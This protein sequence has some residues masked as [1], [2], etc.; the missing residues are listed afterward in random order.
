MRNAIFVFAL[1]LGA[2]GSVRSQ[3]DAGKAPP[4]AQDAATA[5]RL[6]GYLQRWEQEMRKVQTLAAA[7]QRTDT[8]KTFGTKTTFVGTAQY[9]K[10]GTGPTSLNLAALELKQQGKSEVA[11]KFICTGTY[12][13]KFE[14]A[15]KEIRAYKMPKPQPGQVAD[16]SF[17]GF[18]F[19]MRAE[20]AKRRYNL[21]FSKAPDAPN[22]EN[23]YYIYV[24]VTPR[25]PDDKAEFARARLV[26]NKDNF[27]PR[28]L[29]FEHPNGSETVWDIPRIQAG[30]TLDRR[31]FDAPK[32]VPGS[33]WKLVPMPESGSGAGAAA[34]GVPPRVIRQKNN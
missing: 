4:P 34:P 26:L 13:Y 2:G 27:L 11:D 28:Q 8:D 3:T 20:V 17:L 24:D 18:L 7:L 12:L 15:Q 19:G 33:G 10:S 14:V 21:S 9:M 25:F 6:D 30:L 29:W 23:Q 32:I 31:L 5:A 1:L 22:G 16:E